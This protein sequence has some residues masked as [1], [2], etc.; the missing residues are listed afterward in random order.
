MNARTCLRIAAVAAGMLPVADGAAP[1]ADLPAN[2]RWVVHLDVAALRRS[3]IGPALLE[4][5]SGEGPAAK[6]RAFEALTSINLTQDVNSVTLCGRG[7]R[8]EGGAVCLHGRLDVRRLTAILGGSDGFRSENHGPH[9]ILSWDDNRNPAR[10]VRQFGSFSTNGTF[11]VISDRESMVRAVLDV[12]DGEAP[13]LD[14]VAAFKS[15]DL[16]A[17]NAILSV[18]TPD[19]SSLVGDNPRAAVFRQ[20]RGIRL[21]L[22]SEVSRLLLDLDLEAATDVAA[23]QI[24]QMIQGFQAMALLQG[25]ERP[26][27][28]ALAQTLRVT[29]E[30][31]RVRASLALDAASAARLLREAPERPRGN[32][33]RENPAP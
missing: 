25:A 21:S 23:V 30:G 2:S 5:L 15:L 33:G 11:A 6:L 10:A 3:A 18:M 8:D 1:L 32:A 27:I 7:G 24:Q 17:T 9:A 20:A 16:A 31:P 22:L 26:E 29:A 28:A 12:L 14:K 19:A 13:G 4:R